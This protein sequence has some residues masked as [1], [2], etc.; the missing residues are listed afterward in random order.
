VHRL[1][2]DLQMKMYTEVN[3]DNLSTSI[4]EYKMCK[5]S[6]VSCKILCTSYLVPGRV[7]M[8]LEALL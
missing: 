4:I 1:L 3:L 5:E 7:S 6:I 2:L 8:S